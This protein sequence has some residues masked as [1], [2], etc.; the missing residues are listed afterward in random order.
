VSEQDSNS[1]IVPKFVPLQRTMHQKVLDELMRQIQ[2]ASGVLTTELNAADNLRYLL[3]T[4]GSVQRA[5]EKALGSYAIAGESI[6]STLTRITGGNMAVTIQDLQNE[7]NDLK[8]RCALLEKGK[9]ESRDIVGIHGDKS[10]DG[11]ACDAV[12]GMVE[13]MIVRLKEFDV[14]LIGLD[15]FLS[16][17]KEISLLPR[18][19]TDLE[20]ALERFGETIKGR[21]K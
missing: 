12:M 20:A 1:S 14:K 7:I 6:E 2:E 3:E 19:I 13:R 18:S 21:T 5:V 15:D 9:T 17:M 8:E 16:I 4:V 10:F 11:E